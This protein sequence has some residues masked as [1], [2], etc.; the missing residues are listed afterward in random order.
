MDTLAADDAADVAI[1]VGI[2]TECGDLCIRHERHRHK[3]K[4]GNNRNAR[5]GANRERN[6]KGGD[7]E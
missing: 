1:H 2:E 4:P 5:H 7:L 6:R 3:D